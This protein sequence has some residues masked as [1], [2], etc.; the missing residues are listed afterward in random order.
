MHQRISLQIQKGE[1]LKSITKHAISVGFSVQV[2]FRLSERLVKMSHQKGRISSTCLLWIYTT[3][4]SASS[5]EDW[6]LFLL[7]KEGFGII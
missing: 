6:F 7:L 4:M 2:Y 3:Q 1:T 5:P